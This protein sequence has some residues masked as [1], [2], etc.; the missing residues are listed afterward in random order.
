[1]GDKQIKFFRSIYFSKVLLTNNTEPIQFT[2]FYSKNICVYSFVLLERVS[3]DLSKSISDVSPLYLLQYHK[4]C[5]F[6][7][8]PYVRLSARSLQEG[9]SIRDFFDSVC[10][11][12]LFQP[13]Y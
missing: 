7:I 13:F 9:E 11:V 10:T 3:Q 4:K 6:P 2:D 5:N 12:P 1:M 8:N